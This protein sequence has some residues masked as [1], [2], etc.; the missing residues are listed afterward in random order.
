MKHESPLA[1][2]VAAYNKVNAEANRMYPIL[3]AFFEQFVGKKIAISGGMIKQIRD[4]L[5]KVGEGFTMHRASDCYSLRYTI[6]RDEYFEKSGGY[7]SSYRAEASLYIGEYNRVS[8]SFHAG[9][10]LEKLLD[11][12][13]PLRTDYTVEEILQARQNFKIA[14]DAKSAAERALYPFG[15]YER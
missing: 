2:R 6:Y 5:P 9:C 15:E 13:E 1:A 14:S 3:R 10:D 8:G 12:F 4:T 11:C 7:G